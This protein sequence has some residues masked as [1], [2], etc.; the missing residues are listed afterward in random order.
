MEPSVTK[1][2]PIARI[3]L[4]FNAIVFLPFKTCVFLSPM[5]ELGAEKGGIMVIE[6]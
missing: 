6:G 2:A 5:T 4:I 1:D 3:D